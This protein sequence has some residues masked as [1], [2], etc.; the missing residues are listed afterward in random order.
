MKDRPI[1]TL[2]FDRIDTRAYGAPF[3]EI[4]IAVD[5]GQM[6]A[7]DFA[8]FEARMH[9]LLAKRY[10]SY[11]FEEKSNPCGFADHVHAYL[12]GDTRALEGIPV[13]TG[14]TEFQRQAWA[15]LR[16][17]PAGR[18]ATYGEQAARIGR[19][20]AVRAIGAANGQNP[21][22]IVVPCHRVIGG[23]NQLTGYA[24]GLAAKR[25]LLSHEGA[26]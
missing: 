21:V 19:P 26:L 2:W 7:L 18:T 9:A 17:I 13:S 10:D 23:G 4:L 24:G 12:N 6:C 14:G 5:R 3:A 22:A 25:W 15:A 20:R 1:T 16:Q 8:G 11:Q